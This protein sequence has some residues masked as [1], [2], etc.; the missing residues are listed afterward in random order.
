M[1]AL[2]RSTIPNPT[3]AELWRI[4]VIRDPRNWEN[5]YQKFFFHF[6]ENKNLSLSFFRNWIPSA[7]QS[8]FPLEFKSLTHSTGWN[9]TCR[10]NNFLPHSHKGTAKLYVSVVPNILNQITRFLNLQLSSE[11]VLNP[12]LPNFEQ[13]RPI[14]YL[15]YSFTSTPSP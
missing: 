4:H 14:N 2:D 12:Y 6:C 1:I 3:H 13:T 8:N 11:Q 9:M 5:N 7:P 10:K 15:D